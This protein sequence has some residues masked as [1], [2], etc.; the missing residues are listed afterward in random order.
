M[1][2]IAVTSTGAVQGAPGLPVV[3][4]HLYKGQQ[5]EP[6]LY[7]TAVAAEPGFLRQ[8]IQKLFLP[9]LD[10]KLSQVTRFDPCARDAEHTMLHLE[11]AAFVAA[12]NYNPGSGQKFAEVI[13]RGALLG[14]WAPL[15]ELRAASASNAEQGQIPG[16]R[17]YDQFKAYA[18]QLL[19]HRAHGDKRAYAE[20]VAQF[21]DATCLAAQK[22]SSIPAE[23][24]GIHPNTLRNWIHRIQSE[25]P[26]ALPTI[27]NPD[28]KHPSLHQSVAEP[29][30]RAGEL[31]KLLSGGVPY[32]RQVWVAYS[33]ARTQQRESI[34]AYLVNSVAPKVFEHVHQL[35]PGYPAPKVKQQ[36]VDAAQQIIEHFDPAGGSFRELA[37]RVM[38]QA[39]FASCN[40]A[41]PQRFSS[42]FRGESEFNALREATTAE[43]EKA[44]TYLK[45]FFQEGFNLF[46][47]AARVGEEPGKVKS[48]LVE[49]LREVFPDYVPAAAEVAEQSRIEDP[50][51][52]GYQLAV[53]LANKFIRED[54]A[55]EWHRSELIERTAFVIGELQTLDPQVVEQGLMVLYGRIPNQ[56]DQ[57]IAETWWYRLKD[58][59][60]SELAQH[61]ENVFHR[62]ADQLIRGLPRYAAS[63]NEVRYSAEFGEVL[64]DVIIPAAMAYV[65]NLGTN[66]LSAY[67]LH[68]GLVRE[69]ELTEQHQD[70]RRTGSF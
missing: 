14:L 25:V 54:W 55:K 52:F 65:P 53:V 26:Q 60:L 43:S 21:V 11:L 5:V 56:L 47:I 49:T 39:L 22:L 64:W 30:I 15:S 13:E 67:V 66:S 7:Q 48:C 33:N 18:A 38:P 63:P 29:Q 19:T 23:R 40:L 27:Y 69:A 10:A 62:V 45:L 28:L 34:F 57:R 44:A 3:L 8:A 46:E 17:Q 9:I 41:D 58:S 61:G 37:L 50:R 36:F 12:R 70:A 42:K 31:Q 59:Y 6:N 24:M 20:A 4:Q 1:R 35:L 2:D 68:M 51:V 16:Q 32:S